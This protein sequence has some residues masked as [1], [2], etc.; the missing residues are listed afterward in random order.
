MNKMKFTIAIL[1][2]AVI[3]FAAAANSAF[4]VQ[5]LIEKDMM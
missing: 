3:G 2:A 5:K 1:A 4:V